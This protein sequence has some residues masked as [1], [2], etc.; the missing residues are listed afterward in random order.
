MI[1]KQIRQTS[2]RAF[3]TPVV[4]DDVRSS[5]HRHVEENGGQDADLRVL[6]SANA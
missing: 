2:R 4:E 1:R 6:S 3:I 5:D